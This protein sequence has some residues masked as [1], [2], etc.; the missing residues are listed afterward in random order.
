MRRQTRRSGASRS[1]TVYSFVHFEKNR[2]F[3]NLAK[4]PSV[5]EF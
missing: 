1:L 5:F 3:E 4:S 2:Q